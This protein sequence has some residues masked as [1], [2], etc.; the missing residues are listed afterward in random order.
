MKESQPTAV[1]AALDAVLR[2]AG[3]DRSGRTWW[4]QSVETIHV[5]DL[6]ATASERQMF[7]SAGVYFR[8]LG[9]TTLPREHECHVRIGAE[10]IATRPLV[11]KRALDFDNSDLPLER[12]VGT[13]LAVLERRILP[14]L[15][16]HATVTRARA[17]LRR[18]AVPAWPTPDAMRLLGLEGQAE[19]SA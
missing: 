4:R 12:R 2:S 17:A 1:F 15:D 8:V 11:L 10:E 3:F 5:V 6:Q 13:V 14:W 9:R 7:L 19:A 16:G 18:G